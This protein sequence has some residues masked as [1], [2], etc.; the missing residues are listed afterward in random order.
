MPAATGAEVALTFQ[1][2][3][4]TDHRRSKFRT[5]FEISYRVDATLDEHREGC[6]CFE[7]V[8]GRLRPAG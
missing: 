3:R 4:L 8:S 5:M 6:Q 1:I 7:A 2:G